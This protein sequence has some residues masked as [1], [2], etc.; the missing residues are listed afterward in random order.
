[1][2]IKKP[3]ILPTGKTKKTILAKSSNTPLARSTAGT[4]TKNILPTGK[5]ARPKK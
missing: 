5:P 3:N 1:M 2:A 4:K